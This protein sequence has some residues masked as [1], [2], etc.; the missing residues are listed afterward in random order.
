MRYF[1]DC[2][3]TKGEKVLAN[4][5]ICKLI[6]FDE[7]RNLFLASAYNGD[8]VSIWSRIRHSN[9]NINMSHIHK[10][11]EVK[12]DFATVIES[13]VLEKHYD[14]FSSPYRSDSGVQEIISMYIDSV[15]VDVIVKHYR[16]YRKTL[17]YKSN[18]EDIQEQIEILKSKQNEEALEWMESEGVLSVGDKVELKEPNSLLANGDEDGFKLHTLFIKRVKYR[19]GSGLPS[20]DY[21]FLKCKKNGKPSMH[22]QYVRRSTIKSSNIKLIER[23]NEQK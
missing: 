14:I 7:F 1:E 20:I 16:E 6:S 9:L 5:K 3:Y 11:I 12:L 19:F 10:V 15:L 2:V 13:K 4:T 21:S 8:V 17:V 22:E 23:K 18:Y